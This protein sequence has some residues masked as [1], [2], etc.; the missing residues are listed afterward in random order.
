MSWTLTRR[1]TERFKRD[2]KSSSMKPW[3]QGYARP[4]STDLW[5]IYVRDSLLNKILISQGTHWFEFHWKLGRVGDSLG[6]ITSHR[7]WHFGVDPDITYLTCGW[8]YYRVPNDT[9]LPTQTTSYFR[10]R[11]T[12][13]VSLNILWGL[14]T[15][16]ILDQSNVNRIFRP[17]EVRKLTI[18][19]W[20]QELEHNIAIRSEREV[21]WENISFIVQQRIQ[22]FLIAYSSRWGGNFGP[23]DVTNITPKRRGKN[24]GVH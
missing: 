10:P 1:G 24:S 8:F 20:R 5:T 4:F 21:S 18:T 9:W 22:H 15:L 6:N 16:P 12:R 11:T 23:G 7:K 3:R 17:F 2:G 13:A 19:A 14:Q